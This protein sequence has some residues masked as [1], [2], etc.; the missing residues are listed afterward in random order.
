MAKIEMD[1]RYRVR[2]GYPVTLVHDKAP[3]LFPFI[4]YYVDENGDAVPRRWTANGSARS[5]FEYSRFDLIEVQSAVDVI[6]T[7]LTETGRGGRI[8]AKIID[9]ALRSADMLKEGV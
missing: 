6:Y 9:T 8:T 3:G 1:G 7:A 5:D 2:L 4:G